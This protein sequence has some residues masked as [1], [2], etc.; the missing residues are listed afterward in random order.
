MSA[1]QFICGDDD[2]LVD[3]AGKEAFAELSAGLDPE[4][5]IEVIDGG[6]ANVDG[7]ANAVSA[8]LSGV[9]TLSLFGDRKAVW[10]RNVNFLADSV[11]GRAEGAK[12]QVAK[13]QEELKAVDPSA[14]A[15]LITAQPVDRRRKE[16]KWFQKQVAMTDLKGAGDPQEL[17]SLL[18][19]EAGDLGV[20]LEGAAAEALI[21]LVGGQTRLALGELR[22]LATYA[23]AGVVEA[24]EAITESLV[25][26]L[27][28]P[29][30]ESDFFE[31][32]EAFFS[33]KL[34][35]TLASLDRY[36][37]TNKEARPVLASLSNRGRLT[38]QIRAAM[39]AGLL[40]VGPRGFKK[41]ALAAAGSQMSA[42]FGGAGEKS[43]YNLF[44]QN[45]WYLGNKVAPAA[46]LFSLRDLMNFQLAFTQA[47]RGILDRPN[48][49]GTV[50]RN[51]ALRCL[52]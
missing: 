20:R 43:A 14:V 51:M 4:F 5:G 24:P 22:K 10:L 25:I 48:D 31:P 45:E 49:Q 39:D 41:G 15:V 27:V 40:T 19:R 16:F 28:P 30:G 6:A 33:G 35:W 8:F 36:F 1:V 3:R 50:L 2:F 34:D 13:L 37:F 11:T 46:Q 9:R 44:T 47:F 18:L 17:A 23:G 52:G 7:V 32:V 42:V 38:L 21:S 29:V 26:Q 12:A